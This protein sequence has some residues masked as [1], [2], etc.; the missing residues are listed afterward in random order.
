MEHR[1][2][3]EKTKFFYCDTTTEWHSILSTSL[4]HDGAGAGLQRHDYYNPNSQKQNG[5]SSE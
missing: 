1:H 3:E 2:R 4:I 5:F